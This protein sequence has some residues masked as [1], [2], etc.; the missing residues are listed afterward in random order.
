MKKSLII[1]LTS[2][3]MVSVLVGPTLVVAQ[4][5]KNRFVFQDGWG[6][7]PPPMHYNLFVR[8]S[9]PRTELTL[10]PLAFYHMGNDSW[11]P[12][13]AE[14]WE[15]SEDMLSFTVHLRED[16]DWSDGS[17]FTSKDVLCTWYVG[18]LVAW[19]QWDYIDQIEAVDDYTVIF[20][21]KSNWALWDFHTLYTRI[22]G[23]YS[24]YGN[25][26][27][28]AKSAMEAG[29]EEGLAQL[30]ADFAD[31]RPGPPFVGT[32][33]FDFVSISIDALLLKK[34][35]EWWGGIDRIHF[36]EFYQMNTGGVK[37]EPF[38][39]AGIYDG[40]GADWTKS[41]FAEMLAKYERGEN[42]MWK[43]SAR[44]GQTLLFNLR[45]YPLSLLD[46]R[47]AIAYGIN[48]T[49]MSMAGSPHEALSW[50]VIWPTGLEDESTHKYITDEELEEYFEEYEYDPTK[51][52]EILEGLGF[53]KGADG[54][55][56][57]PNGTR[58]EFDF[59]APPWA[60]W[61]ICAASVGMQLERIGIKAN[62]YAME[63]VT[64]T[65]VPAGD[66]DLAFF[67]Y[68]EN[69]V[70]PF[71]TFNRFLVDWNMPGTGIGFDPVQEVPWIEEP[72]DV[73]EYTTSILGELDPAKRTETIKALAYVSNYYLP[74]LQLRMKPSANF[75]NTEADEWLPEGDP[76]YA[77]SVRDGYNAY[78]YL[79]MVGGAKPIEEPTPPGPEVEVVEVVPMWAYGAMGVMAV[80]TVG[81][82]AVAMRK[83]A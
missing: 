2:V 16:V 47:R 3:L 48:R 44:H 81:A 49:E 34:R 30:S 66:F 64:C 8:G 71:S 18:K 77:W 62:V 33:P 65:R 53:E 50:P 6:S 83:R 45:K 82:I 69:E 58:L 46:V 80:I 68:T 21:L 79:I 22:I 9:L 70:V 75:Y 51:A 26:S 24:V 20:H 35:D 15:L 37:K 39:L 31:F 27:D 7:T 11:V 23:A 17:H 40:G 72:I 54:I 76:W 19:W 5:P 73:K 61:S 74:F 29:D 52:M 12:W 25:W 57:T 32:G 28:A 1:L 59:I 42:Y 67:C 36:D 56:V 78:T 43:G 60:D 14:S 10:E 4:K 55:Y 13:L 38:Y 63:A 41:T